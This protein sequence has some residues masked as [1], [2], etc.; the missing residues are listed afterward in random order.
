MILVGILALLV[1][2]AVRVEKI[3]SLLRA[4]TRH[5]TSLDN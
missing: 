5:M 4:L 1:F 2:V 3:V